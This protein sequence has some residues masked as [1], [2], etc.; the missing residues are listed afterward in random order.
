VCKTCNTPAQGSGGA[1]TLIDIWVCARLNDFIYTYYIHLNIIV[2]ERD[3]HSSCQSQHCTPGAGVSPTARLSRTFNR[4]PLVSRS[5]HEKRGTLQNTRA[6]AGGRALRTC[7]GL[8]KR[9]H[10]Q[11][12]SRSRRSP[13]RGPAQTYRV[14][15]KL[16]IFPFLHKD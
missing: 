4:P 11:W 13:V 6:R 14:A 7:K 2:I 5:M 9:V 16:H 10:A 15:V 12:A 3:T 1:H 8:P